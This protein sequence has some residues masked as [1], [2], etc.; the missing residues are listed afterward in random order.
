MECPEGKEYYPGTKKCYKKCLET[1]F[2][3]P[4]TRRCKNKP[5]DVKLKGPKK[6]KKR[7]LNLDSFFYSSP[8]PFEE[9]EPEYP[10]CIT[11]SKIP[12]YPHQRRV[13]S[14]LSE[15][16]GIIAIHDVGTGKTLTAVTAGQCFLNESPNHKV[17]VV[18]PVSLQK[19]FIQTLE[20][21]GV[22]GQDKKRFKFYTIQGFYT[23]YKNKLVKDEEESMLIL[24]EAHNIR[25]N[26]GEFDGLEDPIQNK[27]V[28]V[29]AKALISL[30][31]HVKRVLLLTA[32]P[33]VNLPADMINL[34]AI[35]NGEKEITSKE[36]YTLEFKKWLMKKI[37]IYV[38]SPEFF[39]DKFPRSTYHDVFLTM[40]P[41]YYRAYM[42]V[43]TVPTESEMAF[44]NGLR[45]VSNSLDGQNS[46]KVEWI[47]NHILKSGKNHKFVVFSHYLKSGL[48]LV[49]KNLKDADIPFLYINGS[50]SKEKRDYAV[51]E[52]NSNKIKVLLISKAGGEG[53]DLKN[54]TGIILMNPSWN[55][56]ANK[57]IIGRGVRLESHHSLPLKSRHV[58]IYKLF[59]IKPEE[60][61]DVKKICDDLD[62]KN[63]TKLLSVDLYMRNVAMLKEA[64]INKFYDF[65][66]R[67]SI[68]KYPIITTKIQESEK[69]EYIV[70]YPAYLTKNPEFD[71]LQ[72]KRV[73]HFHKHDKE[74]YKVEYMKKT[75]S[76]WTLFDPI[77]N[78]DKR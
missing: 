72:Y 42:R 60:K 8:S 63:K 28:G 22:S 74:P 4:P 71:K 55:E 39:K 32:T 13:V 16:R 70:E 66:K 10:S 5:T 21:Y 51:S 61:K 44:Y 31:K 20:K 9:D 53:L 7:T 68:E 38:P 17:I 57:Q 52:Y 64:E 78:L 59:M 40:P 23:A 46:P 41:P 76:E 69:N 6:T 65:M 50:L 11:N 36:F 27:E 54:T 58:D 56:S 15:N 45:Q 73:E 43:E 18:T 77:W 75:G 49:M 24:D 62:I 3:N 19:N 34:I 35:V 12:L 47:M 30:G 67:F 26:Q 29:Y 25:T 2:R 48:E 14:F 37:S 1:Q 33:M